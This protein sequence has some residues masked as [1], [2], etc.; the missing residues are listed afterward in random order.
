MTLDKV[1]VFCLSVSN[2]VIHN[3]EWEPWAPS[4][5][6]H[7]GSWVMTFSNGHATDEQ[8]KLWHG[9]SFQLSFQCCVIINARSV[10]WHMQTDGT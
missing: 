7:K 9:P 4:G 6:P 8:K 10:G 2:P 5:T 1:N 3:I